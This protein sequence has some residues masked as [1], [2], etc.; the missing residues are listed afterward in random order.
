MKKALIALL[1]FLAVA[2]CST[3]KDPEPDLT[4]TYQM[5]RLVD[6]ASNI[7]VNLPTVING[8]NVS[9]TIQV[10]RLKDTQFTWQG[11]ITVNGQTTPSNVVPVELRKA[12]GR[13]YDIIDNGTRTGS[14]DGTEFTID[15]MEKTGRVVV[16]GR[17]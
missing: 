5:T 17:K 1:L 6:P 11:F 16:A 8:R 9:G 4:G 12:S 3:K 13:T 15:Y 2:A 14:T 10:V 7:D